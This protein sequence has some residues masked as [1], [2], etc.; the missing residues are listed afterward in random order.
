MTQSNATPPVFS[1]GYSVQHQGDKLYLVEHHTFHLYTVGFVTALIAV[2]VS[3]NTF[4]VPIL[5]HS[6]GQSPV[7]PGVI[8]FAFALAAWFAFYRVRRTIQRRH[9]TPLSE[10]DVLAIIDLKRNVLCNAQEA[11]LAPLEQVFLR[12]QFRVSSSSPA[13][14]LVWPD[15]NTLVFRGNVFSGGGSA[16]IDTLQRHGIRVI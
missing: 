10:C 8:L 16:P 15:G 13:Y 6:E 7:I 11:P 2:L 12:K 9:R 14:A 5:I 3:V 4:M 1:S